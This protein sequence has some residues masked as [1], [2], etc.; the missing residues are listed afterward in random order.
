[1]VAATRRFLLQRI[2]MTSALLAGWTV[3]RTVR[4][5]LT[6]V[7]PKL[8]LRYGFSLT[9]KARR[10]L[11]VSAHQDDLELFTAGTLRLLS[12]AGSH[13]TVLVASGGDQQYTDVRSLDQIREQ[14]ERDA[15]T[16]I[17]Y[18]E[19]RFL[20]FSDL[21]LSHNPGFQDKLRAI[22]Q[23]LQPD[24]VLTFDPTAPY[25][26]AVHPDHLAVGRAVLSIARAL[27][28]DAPD[29]LFYGSRDPNVLVDISQV[30]EDKAAAIRAHRSQL[31]GWKRFYGLVTRMQARLAGRPAGVQYAEPLRCLSL[32]KLSDASLL[33]NWS[34]R[35]PQLR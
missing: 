25:R 14:E 16:I 7:N 10:V 31:Y 13:I 28:D 24:L 1:M 34:A 18:D 17:G 22:W 6:P 20:R 12:L 9:R 15:G 3:W 5:R 4:R 23:N 33:T 8:A 29:V 11:A 2:W 19:I 26:S 30:V 32:P 35:E 27:G 21:E